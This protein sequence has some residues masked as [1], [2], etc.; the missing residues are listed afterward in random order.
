MSRVRKLSVVMKMVMDAAVRDNMI[1][2]NPV[3]GVKPPRIERHEAAYFAPEVVESIAEA[4]PNGEY[5]ILIR[6]L[7]VGG[8]RFGE[9]AALTRQ[10]ID[11]VRKRLLVQESLT[12]VGGKLVRTSTKTYQHRQV[13]LPTSLAKALVAHLDGAVGP[14]A[15]APV[16]RAPEGGELRYRAFHGRCGSRPSRTWASPTLAFMC[17]GTRR[18]LG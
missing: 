16:F 4:M 3:V 10:H 11:V 5:A 1:R 13:P 14:E 2:A 12:E 8:L 18:P 17:C 15:S 6:V 7:G 9:A